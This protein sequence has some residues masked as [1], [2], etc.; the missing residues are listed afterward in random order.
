[1]TAWQHDLSTKLVATNCAFC[2]RKLRDAPS[3]KAGVGADCAAQYGAD[4][5]M[6]AS[7]REEANKIIYEI[8]I[9][10]TSVQ[11]AA[12]LKRLRELGLGSAVERISA[13][14]A[15][16][17]KVRIERRDGVFAIYVDKEMLEP[18][19]SEYVGMMRHVEGR[20]FESETKANVIPA[21]RASIDQT[22]MVLSTLFAGQIIE[23]P[24]GISVIP[25]L[26]ELYATFDAR[27]HAEAA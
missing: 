16:I 3:L 9:F 10:Q 20:R 18:V 1:M 15:K 25:T 8:A 17:V 13:R 6:P 14:L 21:W 22:K 12:R 24:R 11:T 5:G 19:F 23:T 4:R 7:E 27:H 2:G 26:D